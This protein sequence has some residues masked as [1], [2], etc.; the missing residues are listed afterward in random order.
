MKFFLLMI[1]ISACA[2]SVQRQESVEYKIS[3]D[4]YQ[5]YNIPY[6][7]EARSVEMT[8]PEAPVSRFVEDLRSN[9]G[10]E[11]QTRKPFTIPVVSPS[12]M[13]KLL[14][15]MKKEEIDDIAKSL[16]LQNSR[17]NVKCLGQKEINNHDDFFLVLESEDLTRVRLEILEVFRLRGGDLKDFVATDYTPIIP[18]NETPSSIENLNVKSDKSCRETVRATPHFNKKGPVL[19]SDQVI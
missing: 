15:Q 19:N 1:L 10:E 9:Q 2:T 11:F 13:E 14:T 3:S 6:A 12:E 18:L 5:T 8:V 4:L 17:F 16:Y 7:K